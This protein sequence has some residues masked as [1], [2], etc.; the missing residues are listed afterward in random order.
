M[1]II[2]L[3]TSSCVN[4]LVKNRLCS[5]ASHCMLRVT[6]FVF[7]AVEKR[8][9]TMTSSNGFSIL[10]G[11]NYLSLTTF[12]KTGQAVSTPVW[13]ADVDGKLVVTT[14][15]K[16]GKAKRI[17]N[18][19]AVTVAPCDMRGQ[20]LGPAVQATARILTPE[21]ATPADRALLRKYGWQMRLFRLSRRADRSIFLEI[22]AT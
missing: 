7:W 2:T 6:S 3:D 4:L 14:D 21:E 19:P 9:Q 12:R 15:G 11:H 17:R 16:S 1:S 18:N 20:V 22:T 13:F 10:A 5:T 8:E